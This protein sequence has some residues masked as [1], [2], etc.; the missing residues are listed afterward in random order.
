M[1][2]FAS[3]FYTD[4]Y[5]AIKGLEM[6]DNFKMTPCVLLFQDQESFSRAGVCFQTWR[7]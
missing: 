5:I 4:V 6:S 7:Y 1:L 3:L 2:N